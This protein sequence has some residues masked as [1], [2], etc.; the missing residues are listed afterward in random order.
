MT[1]NGVMKELDTAATITDGRTFVPL[2]FVSET[3]GS[4]IKWDG[5]TKT[6]TINTGDEVTSSINPT[7]NEEE[8][9]DETINDTDND[10]L[11]DDDERKLTYTNP[12]KKDTDGNGIT[13][14]L[15]DN[16]R[17]R[18]NNYEEL[19]LGTSPFM[20]DTDFDGL[21]DYQ[22]SQET[23]TNPIFRRY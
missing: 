10:R 4:T 7:I 16:D 19:R 17:D 8:K 3:L 11:A 12:T 1:V 22:E 9:V 13:D 18:L 23:N 20:E 6:V 15:E 21:D 14:D 2:R 5:S